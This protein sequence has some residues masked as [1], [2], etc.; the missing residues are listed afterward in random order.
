MRALRRRSAG[1]SRRQ[2]LEKSAA[3][4]AAATL[5]AAAVPNVHAGE[6]NVIRLA[7]IGCG[8]R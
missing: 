5:A 2:F 4:A 7:L 8:G 3:G 1:V 6:D